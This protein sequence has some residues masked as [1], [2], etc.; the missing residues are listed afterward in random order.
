MSG[1]SKIIHSLCV[2][3]EASQAF[4]LTARHPAGLKIGA[5]SSSLPGLALFQ[6]LQPARGARPLRGNPA[7]HISATHLSLFGGYSSAAGHNAFSSPRKVLQMFLQQFYILPLL[8]FVI[9]EQIRKCRAGFRQCGHFQAIG[10]AGDTRG[11]MG[12]GVVQG[13]ESESPSRLFVSGVI[14]RCEALWVANDIV[15]ENIHGV[16]FDSVHDRKNS[17]EFRRYLVMVAERVR[18]NRKSHPGRGQ[19]RA[20][21]RPRQGIPARQDGWDR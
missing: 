20:A 13:D 2:I 3:P 19:W 1:C 6:G 15:P 21:R 18:Q 14:P 11:C 16:H 12:V 17:L 4:S 9:A 8:W 10:D 7:Q 5:R